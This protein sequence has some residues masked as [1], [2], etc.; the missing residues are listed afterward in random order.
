[1]RS[2][3]LL[4]L[5]LAFAACLA[6][7]ATAA[8]RHSRGAR[9]GYVCKAKNN[10]QLRRCPRL[11]VSYEGAG[12]YSWHYNDGPGPNGEQPTDQRAE[13]DFTWQVAYQPLIVFGPGTVQS[14]ASPD[15]GVA[16]DWSYDESYEGG[17]CASAGTLEPFDNPEY[18]GNSKHGLHITLRVER[19]MTTFAVND[20]VVLNFWDDFLYGYS[21]IQADAPDAL[22]SFVDVPA[23]QLKHEKKIVIQTDNV[24]PQAPSLDP[25]SDCSASFGPTCTQDFSWQGTVTIKKKRPRR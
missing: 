14:F 12:S 4:A 18:D 25:P 15:D 9:G 10:R 7:V 16:G 8:P 2:A 13:A 11:K 1:M 23:Q 21:Q 3:R 6:P 22:A 17:G 24:T 20:C 5:S 19:P